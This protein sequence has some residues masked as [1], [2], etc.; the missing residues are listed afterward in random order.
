MLEVKEIDVFYRKVQAL[1][2]VSILVESGEIVIVL[3]ANGAGK[4]TLLK[5]ISGLSP[6]S[7]GEIRFLGQAIHHKD[8]S[9][10]VQ[11]GICH[12]PEGRRVFPN[13]T[14]KKNLLIG[15]YVRRERGEIWDD[16][17][18]NFALF[19]ILMERKDQL[20]GS[21]SGGEQQM[22]A[23]ARSL[24]GRPKLLILDEPSLGL[25]PILVSTVANYIKRINK[26]GVDILLVEQNARVALS[27][28]D[29]GYVLERGQ[30]T[31]SGASAELIS[32]KEIV[33]AYLGGQAM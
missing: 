6:L 12:C 2:R 1:R 14:V 24:M 29:R 18:R 3:G 15:A 31:I 9:L 21:L 4:S 26:Q 33:Q 8:P 19:P 32:R 20:A 11:A 7:S 17:E 16:L 22:L 27:I 23:I 5:S 28:A 10:I 30:I 25:S 13:M